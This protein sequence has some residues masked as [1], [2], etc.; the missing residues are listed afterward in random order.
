MST[1]HH[2]CE[3]R[4]STLSLTVFFFLQVIKK[5]TGFWRD[6]G[7]GMTCQY[8]SDFINIGEIKLRVYRHLEATVLQAMS[9][10]CR[11]SWV[12][13]LPF[14]QTVLLQRSQVAA[15]GMLPDTSAPLRC[16][17]YHSGIYTQDVSKFRGASSSEDPGCGVREE[18]H[19]EP[20]GMRKKTGVWE[21]HMQRPMFH[22][23]D[24]YL[25]SHMSL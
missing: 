14:S 6:F 25:K 5:E 16:T 22:S 4:F 13:M 7:F 17:Q 11:F 9:K 19:C 21:K 3:D 18:E 8:Q 20:P 1:A 2:A 10:F 23:R 24:P 15:L 12:K